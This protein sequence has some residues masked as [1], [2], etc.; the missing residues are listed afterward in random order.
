MQPVQVSHPQRDLLHA[1]LVAKEK[2]FLRGL[3]L[4]FQ[5]LY[6]QL[7]FGDLV[8]DPQQVFLGAGELPLRF[9]LAVAEAG[10]ARGLLEY[11]APVGGL[12]GDDLAD[13]ALAD[14]RVAVGAQA[15]VHQQ[16][17]HVT[18][19]HLLAVD[20]VFALAAAVVAAG[21]ADLVRVQRKHPG[22]VVEDQRDLGKAHGAS[23]LRAAEDDVLHLSAAERAR[24]LLAHDPQK[25]VGDV[26][27]A[28][29]VGAYDHR[30]IFFKAQPRLF[31][32]RL[33]SLDLQSFDIHVQ[34]PVP[35]Y[36]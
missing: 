8:S 12:G 24:P 31:R 34:S 14:D 19:A 7:Q 35:I 20:I 32:K 28:A 9:V 2:V 11:L 30:Y 25:G 27:L 26:A 17:A 23:L 36:L 15:R 21:D 3:R 29:A 4:F 5:R 10:D 33:E 1:Q 13:A 16:L 18:K 22:G 6:L